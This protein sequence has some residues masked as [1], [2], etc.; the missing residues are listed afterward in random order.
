MEAKISGFGQ[1]Q[2]I[3]DSAATGTKIWTKVLAHISDFFDGKRDIW[4]TNL[5]SDN[6]HLVLSG[7]ALSVNSTELKSINY[8]PIRKQ[9]VYKFNAIFNLSTFEKEKK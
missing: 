1:T 2:A 8:E 7:Y 4:L 3:L 5:N 6:K 9:N